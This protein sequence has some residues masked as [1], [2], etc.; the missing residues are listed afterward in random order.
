M[1]FDANTGNEG[2]FILQPSNLLVFMI[3][4]S[5]I[6]VCLSILAFTLVIQSSKGFIYLGFLLASSVLREFLYYIANATELP[7]D[8]PVCNL[9]SYGKFGNNTYSSFMLAFTI[10]YLCLP[11]YLNDSM[12]WAL[13][14]ALLSYIMGDAMIRSLNNCVPNVSMLFLNVIGGFL[15]GFAMVSMMSMGGSSKYMFFNEVQSDKVICTRPKKQQFKC[16][17][18]KNGDLVTSTTV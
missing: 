6:I 7:P 10:V 13:F 15:L 14:G 16:A 1:K 8:S 2:M 12:N 5:P 9:I 17:V 4:Y 18:Y 3:F 11:M